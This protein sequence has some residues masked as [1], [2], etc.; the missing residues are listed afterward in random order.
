MP[1]IEIPLAFV[2]MQ[3]KEIEAMVLAY[4]GTKM[5]GKI[6]AGAEFDRVDFSSKDGGWVFTFRVKGGK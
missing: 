1:T 6:P 4:I 3:P 5:A 2:V